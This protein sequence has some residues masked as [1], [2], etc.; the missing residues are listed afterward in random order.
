MVA[1]SRYRTRTRGTHASRYP[2]RLCV[3]QE[4]HPPV[5]VMKAL[6][7]FLRRERIRVTESYEVP[8][9]FSARYEK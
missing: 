2:M 6:N 9:T 7:A 8:S 4:A 1:P 5:T 3:L